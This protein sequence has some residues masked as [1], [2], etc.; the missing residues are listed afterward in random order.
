M[1]SI[2]ANRLRGAV[3]CIAAEIETRVSSGQKATIVDDKELWRELTC[4]VLS[5]QVPYEMAK[6][7]AERI[8]EAGILG[9]SE[10]PERAILK[11]QLV[12]QLLAPLPF[13]SAVRRYRFPYSRAGQIAAAFF[14]VREAHGSLAGFLHHQNDV[15]FARAWLATHVPGVGPKQASMF[16]RNAAGSFDLAILDRH[17]LHY[18]KTIDLWPETDLD[19]A[20]ISKYERCEA[21]LREYADALGHPVG[22][23]DWAIWIVMRTASTISSK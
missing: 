5:S 19:V 23:L 18:M 8:D 20:T 21:R 22:L 16:L 14:V 6:A 17:V 12:R 7:A 3:T 10:P 9:Q 15:R 13:D 2:S 4:C 11:E 1:N